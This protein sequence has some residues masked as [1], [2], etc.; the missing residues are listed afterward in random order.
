MNRIWIAQQSDK[1]ASIVKRNN[2]PRYAVLL[3]GIVLVLN[4]V[5]FIFGGSPF[6][7][8][9]KNYVKSVSAES[10]THINISANIGDII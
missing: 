6:N 5:L 7:R 10:A 1:E 4:I 8:V 9:N 2:I 3:I